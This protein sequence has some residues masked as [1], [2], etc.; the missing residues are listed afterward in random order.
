MRSMLLGLSFVAALLLFGGLGMEG[1]TT[2]PKSE[3]P[4]NNDGGTTD[5]APKD[6]KKSSGPCVPGATINECDGDGTPCTAQ[7]DCDQISGKDLD[8][9]CHAKLCV[10]KPTVE[11]KAPEKTLDLSC[12]DN[13]P[14]LPSGPEKAVWVGPVETFGLASNTVGVTVDIFDYAADPDLKTP[15]AT[16]VSEEASDKG[17]ACAEKCAEDRACFYGRCVKKKDDGNDIGYFELK[18]IPTN[19][20]VVLRTQGPNLVTTVQY[21]LWIPADKTQKVGE[22]DVFYD[23]AFAITVLTRG[24]IPPTA[25]IR[26][27]KPDE[28]VV[29][30]EVHDCKDQIVEGAKVSLSLTPQKLAYFNGDAENP[31]P[32]Q[33]YTNTDGIYA[34]LN[35]KSPTPT[36]IEIR[37]T[38]LV[39]GKIKQIAKFKAKVFPDAATIVTTLPWYPGIE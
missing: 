36:D 11:A 10:P 1:C 20:L 15:L 18:D 22:T 14:S 37:A 7:R 5:T 12:L 9:T 4:T 23:R 28:A 35:L 27:P 13:P 39:G 32:D 21:L 25:G 24:L 17:G 33:E 31:D 26:L 30:G 3:T 34:A 6:E 16:Y 29:A 2:P 19:K 38:V 8:G